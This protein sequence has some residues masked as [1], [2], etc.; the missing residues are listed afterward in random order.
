MST[1]ITFY[2]GSQRQFPPKY[3]E[4]T[5]QAIQIQSTF[6]FLEI[7]S[8]WRYKIHIRSVILGQLE[9]FRNYQGFSIIFPKIL[10]AILNFTKVRIFLILLAITFLNPKILGFLFLRKMAKLRSEMRKINLQKIEGN[11]LDK[12]RKLYISGTVIQNFLAFLKVQKFLGIFCFS[13]QIF[14]RK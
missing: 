3:I 12:L 6:S 10:D 5:F 1:Q 13:E 11:L 9:S 8:N 7:H 4:N 14:Y 2:R